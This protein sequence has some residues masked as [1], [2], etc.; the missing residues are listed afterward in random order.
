MAKNSLTALTTQMGAANL[1]S[2]GTI[3]AL[4]W[5]AGIAQ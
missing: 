4:G 1:T 3:L 2:E 5:T